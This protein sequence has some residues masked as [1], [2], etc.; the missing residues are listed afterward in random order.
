MARHKDSLKIQ[1]ADNPIR[2]LRKKARMTQMDA[3]L[4][5]D[6]S[7]STIGRWEADWDNREPT[8]TITQ[9]KNLLEV[10]NLSVEEL[11]NSLINN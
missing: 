1:D 7:L 9:F 5:I 3:A 2:R 10:F 11:P 4:A 6:V 8:F